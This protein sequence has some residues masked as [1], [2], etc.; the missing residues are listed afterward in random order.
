MKSVVI[1]G[2]GLA[3][4]T[5]GILLRR[6]GI[7]VTLFE[8]GHY[9]RH[10]V[11]GEFLSGRG[12][13]VLRGLQLQ[14][15]FVERGALEAKT[16]MFF[17]RGKKALSLRLGEPALCLSRF[18]M[19]ALLAI[20]FRR[21]GGELRVGERFQCPPQA[22]GVV[23]A[24]GRR[25]AETGAG[26]LFGLKAHAR[27][28]ELSADL[29]MHFG[30]GHY[31]GICRIPGAKVNVCG[32]FF[33][34]QPVQNVQKCWPTILAQ[35][36]FSPALRG[37]DWDMES[38]C[39]VAGL[40]MDREMMPGEFAIGDAAAMIPPLTGNG[41]SM[42]F[43]SASASAPFLIQ[44]ARGQAE[45]KETV[46]NFQQAWRS[47]FADRLRWAG[48]VQRLAFRS[49]AQWLFFHAARLTPGIPDLLFSRTR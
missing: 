18:E 11:C 46:D 6:E 7:S 3:G 48:L 19:D 12:R 45:W 47:R 29:E 16:S 15:A 40:S 38:F 35:S 14:A 9:P 10:R 22:E 23:R 5:L 21:Q 17:L 27:H 2:G 36:V 33:S 24:T 32:L 44:Y 28:A 25:R 20:E 30:R 8:A 37:V 42:A 41:M 1:V 13:E 39:T 43:E 31:V 26:H 4:L 34:A 49:A